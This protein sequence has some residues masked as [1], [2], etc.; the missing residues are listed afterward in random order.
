M[1]ENLSEVVKKGESE[2]SETKYILIR[3]EPDIKPPYSSTN[4]KHDK[5][6]RMK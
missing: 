2:G 1:S 6:E 4:T 3:H 5:E